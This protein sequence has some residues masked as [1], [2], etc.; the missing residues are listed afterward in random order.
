MQE[1]QTD[2]RKLEAQSK[3]VQKVCHADP[4]VGRAHTKTPPVN[5][6]ATHR[7]ALKH[8]DSHIPPE[9]SLL[10]LQLLSSRVAQPRPQSVGSHSHS[11]KVSVTRSL[12]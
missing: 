5:L 9:L 10:L 2:V 6:T 11:Q 1:L 7:T 8:C 4:V 12:S 3:S